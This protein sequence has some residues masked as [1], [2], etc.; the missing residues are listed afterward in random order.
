M[1]EVRHAL[2]E[3][4]P[5]TRQGSFLLVLRISVHYDGHE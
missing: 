1:R 2:S 4:L 5:L 3:A